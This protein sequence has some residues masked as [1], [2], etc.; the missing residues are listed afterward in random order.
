MEISRRALLGNAGAAALTGAAASVA[1]TV[2]GGGPAAFADTAA[3]PTPNAAS[4]PI[5]PT[6]RDSVFTRSGTGPLYWT[7]YGWSF[8]NNAP[9]PESVWQQNIDWIAGDLAAA[10]YD[11]ACTDGWIDYTQ[12]TTPNGYIR[13][14]NDSWTH[15]WAYWA[16]YLAQKKMTLGVYYNPLWVCRSAVHDT[17]RMV[18]GRPDIPISS[19]VDDG[20]FFGG[21]K[22]NQQLYWVDVTKDGA[23]EYVK[24][25]VEYFKKA[26]AR[27]LR[28]D[29]LSWYESGW[30]QNLG[31]VGI[32][33]GSENY[34]TALRWMSEAT[35]D[36]LELSLVMPNLYSHGANELRYG[37]LVRIDNDA[38]TGGWRHLSG[39]RQT[40]QPGWSQWDTP[41]LGFTG[42][43]DRSGP[44][45]LILDGDF[46]IMHSFANDDERRTV[47]NLFTIAGSPIAVSDRVD[48]IGSYAALYRNPELLALQRKGLAGKPFYHNGNAYEADLSSRDSERWMGQLPDGSWVVGLFNRADGPSPTTKSVDFARDLGVCG[49]ARVRDVWAHADLG[50][51]ASVSA[52][53]NPHA[54]QL[55]T[56]VP[57][58]QIRR[59]Q[60]EFAGRSGGARFGNDQSGYT[61]T[62]FVGSLDRVGAKVVFAVDADR[63]GEYPITLRYANPAGGR[64]TLSVVTEDERRNVI[65]GPAQVAFEPVASSGGW[66]RQAATIRLRAGRNLLTI[67]R[68]ASDTGA[69]RL[70]YVELRA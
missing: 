17:T 63:A 26:G 52:D 7:I 44:G 14:Y 60:A 55:V 23:E 5:P 21:S 22:G 53:L 56:V 68:S 31:T 62:G 59:Y 8:P 61:A 29:F 19:I 25:Y 67:G 9:I 11:M 33:H 50:S 15:D 41:F 24:G 30:E 27:Y 3:A 2:L 69:V 51:A 64:S 34:A 36:D 1:P 32:A 57:H 47:L 35:G 16:N 70:D 28:V 12:Q 39:G 66:G 42:F 20:D 65:G 49:A 46:V 10:G 40:W 4:A 58:E 54:S 43:S 6:S 38:N 45:Q 18:V 48:N 13:S 37:D